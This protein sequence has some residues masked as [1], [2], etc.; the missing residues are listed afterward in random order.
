MNAMG[1]IT[2]FVLRDLAKQRGQKQGV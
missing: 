2:K 1:K